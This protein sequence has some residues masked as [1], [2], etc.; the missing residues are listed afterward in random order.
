MKRYFVWTLA[1]LNVLL[2]GL[3]ILAEMTGAVPNTSFDAELVGFLLTTIVLSMMGALIIVRTDGNRVGWLMLLLG[4]VLANPFQLFLELNMAAL[5]GE[6]SL[7]IYFAFWTQTWFFFLIIYAIFLI[8][9]YFPDGQ[10]PTPRWHWVSRISLF[11]LGQFVLVTIFQPKFGDASAIT[12]DNPIA[13]LSQSADKTLSGVMFGLGM[14]FLM[15]A[16][17]VSIFVRFRRA[18][19]RM[20]AQIKWLLFAGIIAFVAIGF[21]LALYDPQVSNWTDYLMS[22]ALIVL[23]ASISI[24]ILRYRLYDIDLLI[25][26]TLQYTLLTGILALVYFGGVVVL[27]SLFQGVSG[28]GDTPLVTVLS[29]L[30]IASLFNPLRRRTQKWIDRRF[31]RSKYDVETA[32]TDFAETARDEVEMQQ[33]ASKLI[34]VVVHTMQ[35]EDVRIYLK[36][37]DELK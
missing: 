24:A 28:G 3:R 29:T 17:L 12:I 9:L 31:Y 10:P 35:P 6:P 30:L 34:Q 16:S 8:L 1:L 33:L 7:A 19:P 13:R 20:R 14:I 27:Q 5:Q 36:S 15:A 4:F 37:P 18:G 26:K 23:T 25:R 2:A 22:A 32:L 21:N 11:T